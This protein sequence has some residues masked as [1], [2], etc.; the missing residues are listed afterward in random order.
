MKQLEEILSVECVDMAQFG[1]YNYSMS[2]GLFSDFYGV[3]KID[4]AR[5]L[6]FVG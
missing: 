2:I 3:F 4:S 6:L 1:P 5:R